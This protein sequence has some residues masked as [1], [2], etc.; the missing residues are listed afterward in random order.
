MSNIELV[1]YT[2]ID[3]NFADDLKRLRADNRALRGDIKDLTGDLKLARA[4]IAELRN[5]NID[6]ERI[7][8]I[9]IAMREEQDQSFKVSYDMILACIRGRFPDGRG[10]L[11]I[12]FICQQTRLSQREVKRVVR[13]FKALRF[14]QKTKM[15]MIN[16]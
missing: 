7:D 12:T 8:V 3:D 14:S 4:T 1:P 2:L 16:E 13:A 15:V 11:P 6:K 5:V 10:E 9:G